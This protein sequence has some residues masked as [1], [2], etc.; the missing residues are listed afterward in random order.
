MGGFRPTAPGSMLDETYLPRKNGKETDLRRRAEPF[1]RLVP[2][3][4]LTCAV[5]LFNR[6]P[7]TYFDSGR[8][9]TN[10]YAF[11]HGVQPPPLA[12]ALPNP[13]FYRPISYSLFL[14]PF[15]FPSTLWLLPLVQGVLV[16]FAVDL[17]LRCAGV[18]LS[19]RAFLLMFAGLVAGTSLPWFTG[20]VMPD[21]FTSLVILLVFTALWG[22]GR[23]ER[24]EQLTAAAILALGLASHLSHLPLYVALVA[25]GLLL[26]RLFVRE[27]LP[28]RALATRI[29]APVAV[30]LALLVTSNWVV[31][32]KPVLSESGDLFYLAR[33][34]GAGTAQRYLDRACPARR[35]LLCAAREQLH[36]DSDW[37][38][39]DPAGPWVKY[40]N[41]PAFLDDAR[42]I[43][44][45]T[46]RREW[47]RQAIASLRS[48]LR[49][50][51]KFGTEPGWQRS[52]AE[53]APALAVFGPSTVSA[54]W[55]SR[56]GQRALPLEAAGELQKAC[57]W[58]ALVVLL[59][60]LPALW[61]GK[62]RALLALVGVVF[63][64][65]VLNALVLGSLSSV[66]AR[67]QSRVI[68]LVPLLAWATVAAILEARR[69][70]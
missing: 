28:L 68:W 51:G 17:A 29:L 7:L 38:L 55:A 39:W 2:A 37:F 65:L 67:Y 12:G 5:A 45:G 60:C 25:A 4:A 35:Y 41:D 19:T 62:N 59:A 58:L 57:V 36:Q 70:A 8:Y 46:L 48:A 54:Y 22:G 43:V 16:A 10:A 50:A 6:F 9:L 42:A 33:L 53:V 1:W 3:G 49:Q 18:A 61:A 23:L 11:A 40:R 15:A 30:A 63:A 14:M 47:R 24:W 21:F 26:H 69:R 56:Q 66:N 20:Q 44:R 52:E 64:G 27:P 13:F 31:A 32:R 34:V